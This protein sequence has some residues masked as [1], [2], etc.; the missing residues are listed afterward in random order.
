MNKQHNMLAPDW[1]VLRWFNTAAPLS[2]RGLRGRVI[3]VEAFQMLCPGC[4]SHAL[5]QAKRVA[6]LFPSEQ[7]AVIGLHSV[8]EH[9]AAMN[10]AA[11]AAFLHEYRIGFPV[12]VD[13]PVQGDALPKT[14]RAYALRGTPSTVLIDRD[15]RI[16]LS[17][18]GRLDDMRLGA[19]L[20][21]LVAESAG[22]TRAA[23]E[24]EPEGAC[25]AEG[26][27]LPGS[28]SGGALNVR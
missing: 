6:E 23:D 11:L 18:F 9:H 20:M 22:S 27:R 10:P 19:E 17:H 5:P 24:L 25:D 21:A 4:V 2:L 12:A 28:S 7:V 14:M 8:F 15:G 13:A 26:C 1:Q 3:L 16:R